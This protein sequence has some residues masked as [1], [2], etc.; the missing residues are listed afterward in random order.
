MVFRRITCLHQPQFRDENNL[1]HRSRNMIFHHRH[2]HS[3]GNTLRSIF[4]PMN[5]S[6]H[7]PRLVRHSRYHNTCKSSNNIKNLFSGLL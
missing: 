7:H 2:H 6:W 5:L 4:K 3:Y 1:L